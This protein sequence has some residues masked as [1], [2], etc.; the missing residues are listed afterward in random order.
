MDDEEPFLVLAIH[1]FSLLL[2]S[3]SSSSAAVLVQECP[4]ELA[5]F[6]SK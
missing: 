3:S 2:L 1:G 5:P 4:D 6:S